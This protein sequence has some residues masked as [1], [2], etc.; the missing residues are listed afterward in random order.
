MS[1]SFF[2]IGCNAKPCGEGI[3]SV[4]GVRSAGGRF[5]QPLFGTDLSPSF[6]GPLSFLER[7]LEL[8]VTHTG[9]TQL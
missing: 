3:K 4:T 8:I 7:F 2:F 6:Q 1:H 9:V 5:Q